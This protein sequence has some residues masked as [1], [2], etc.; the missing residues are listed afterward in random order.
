MVFGFFNKV[1]I[2]SF[3]TIDIIRVTINFKPRLKLF[4]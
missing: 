3:D 4:D 1:L 2:N